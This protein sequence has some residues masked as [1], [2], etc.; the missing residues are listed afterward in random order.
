M[1]CYFSATGNSLWVA[2]QLSKVLNENLV[3]IVEALKQEKNEITYHLRQEERIIFVYPVHSWGPAVL[4][5]RFI[6]RLK[7]ENY[8]DQAVYSV[9]TCGNDCAYTS[10]IIRKWLAAKGIKLTEGYSI[11]MPNTYILMK[12]FDVD[13]ENVV[14]QKLSE[15]PTVLNRIVA[16][17]EKKQSPKGLYHHTGFSAVKSYIL[18]P[19]FVNFVIGSNSFYA[20]D[21]CLSCG[22]CERICPTGTIRLIDGK[23]VWANTCVQC[24]ACIH[25]CPVGAIE[26]GSIT[27]KKGRYCHSD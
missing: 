12:G 10:R 9:S 6:T 17:I 7:C 14:Q 2:I 15:A 3:S 25:R 23:P 16:A 20:K 24:T 22:V 18:Y 8:T 13:S 26:Y 5:E 1:I 21:N 27:Q 19:I 11:S 4:V